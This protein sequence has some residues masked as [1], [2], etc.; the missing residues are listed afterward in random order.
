MADCTPQEL[1]ERLAKG[2]PPLLVDVRQPEEWAICQIK[3]TL[4]IPMGEIPSRLM[5]LDEHHE[6][7]IVVY[8]HHGVRSGRVQQFL[9]QQGFSNVRNL[10][11]GIDAYADLDPSMARY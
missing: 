6:A 7:E 3:P 11:G 2:T 4:E 9:Q 10:I 5:E 1:K 8:C